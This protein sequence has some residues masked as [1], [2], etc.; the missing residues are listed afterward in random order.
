MIFWKYQIFENFK[1]IKIQ[2]VVYMKIN[3]DVESLFSV[4]NIHPETRCVYIYAI[5][6]F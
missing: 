1:L 4:C 2:T 5:K 6:F 3:V